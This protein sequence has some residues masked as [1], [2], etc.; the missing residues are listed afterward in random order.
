ML[1]QSEARH[2]FAINSSPVRWCGVSPTCLL[3]HTRASQSVWRTP[4]GSDRLRNWLRVQAVGPWALS[5]LLAHDLGAGEVPQTPTLCRS[6]KGAL[7]RPSSLSSRARTP[8]LSV[9]SF[10]LTAGSACVVEKSPWVPQL[11]RECQIQC[12]PWQWVALG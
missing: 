5:V 12:A 7:T 10:T 2:S 8:V 3:K 9:K 6:P 1:S 4:C 11:W